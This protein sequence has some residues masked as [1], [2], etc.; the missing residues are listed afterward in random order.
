M[1]LTNKQKQTLN[2]STRE[3][4]GSTKAGDLFETLAGEVT[5]VIE[6]VSGL[7]EDISD[8]GFGTQYDDIRINPGSFD[9]PGSADPAIVSVTPGGSGTATYLYEWAKNNLACFTV[10]LP[11]SYKLGEEI[12]VHIHWTPGSRGNEED[13]KTVGWK[14]DATWANI[15]GTFG[16]MQSFD[17][18]DICDG[19]DWK[20]QMTPSGVLAGTDK[21]ISSMLLCNIKRTDTGAD[22]TWAGTASGQLPLLLEVD[23]HF[24]MDTAG[25]SDWGSK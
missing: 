2:Y 7:E 22:D 20:H 9:R 13:T 5:E 6:D 11:H 24:P 1:E 15:D 4:D 10:Q 3:I 25:S 17:L 23:F 12:R 21:N 19:V 18:S 8:L 14:I 16:P